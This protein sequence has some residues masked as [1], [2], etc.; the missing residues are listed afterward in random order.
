M[1]IF[2]HLWFLLWLLAVTV[3]AAEAT[4]TTSVGDFVAT[5]TSL[6]RIWDVDKSCD[7]ELEYMEESMSIALDIVTAAHSALKFMKEQVPDKEKDESRY[8]RW[9][10]IYKSIQLFLGFMTNEQPNYLN[11]L[12]DLFAKM[13]RVIPS[14]ENDPAKGYVKRLSR[15]PDAKPMMMCR[16]E[17]GE[18]KWKWYDIDDV[19]PGQQVS[20]A[21]MPGFTKYAFDNY[22]A[23]VYGPRFTWKVIEKEEPILCE[24]GTAAAVAWVKGLIIFCHQLFTAE[25]KAMKSPREFRE[26][27]IVAGESLGEYATHLS[28]VMVHELS[29]WFGG[30]TGNGDPVIDDQTALDNEGKPLYRIGTKL[31]GQRPEPSR[32]EAKAMGWKRVEAYGVKYICN[33]AICDKKRY[34]DH[35]GPGKATKN[36][37]SLALFALAMYYD[38]WDWSSGA[39][40]KEPGSKKRPKEDGG[41]GET[42]K[43][44]VEKWWNELC[45]AQVKQLPLLPDPRPRALTPNLTPGDDGVSNSAPRPLY[46]ESCFWFKVPPNIRRDILRLAF[47]DTRLHMYLNCS[48]PEVPPDP[49]SKFHC[50]ILTEPGDWG[51]QRFP[52]ADESQAEVWQ[53]WGSRCHRCPPNAARDQGPMTHGGSKG[54]WSDLCRNGGDPDICEAWREEEGPSACNI[55]VIGWLLSC[56]QNYMET[57]EVLYST[58]TLIL[59]EA[60]MVEHLPSLIPPRRL[61]MMTSLEI[62]WILKS[63]FTANQDYDNI[64]EGHLQSI[65]DLLSPSKFPALRRLHIWFAKD[66]PAWLSHHGIEA[67]E[68]VIFERLDS[69]VQVWCDLQECA[70]A[71]PRFFFKRKY[72]A[73]RGVTQD[74]R[75][76]L[77]YPPKD[78]SYR[79]VWRDIHGNMTVVQLP[80]VDSYPK[81]PYHTTARDD[82]VAGYW[83]LEAP[84]DDL[85]VYR[86][87]GSPR[88]C[89]CKRS[90]SPQTPRPSRDSPQGHTPCFCP[91][92]PQFS[93]VS[94][95]YRLSSPSDSV[96]GNVNEIDHA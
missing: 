78:D 2:S 63:Y 44:K 95:P 7:E 60:C 19:L 52:V 58:N 79:Q 85:P 3:S 40:A 24:P 29:H 89:I 69:F 91:V 67:Y 18:D 17:A 54:P 1:T 37:D 74:E 33:L 82:R 11:E 55:G 71:L 72:A 68:K 27:G 34:T 57:I 46:Q 59:G 61:E 66:R 96:Q 49:D 53:W 65:F 48:Y 22:G 36:A 14:Q 88:P 75:E 21:N 32:E 93:P 84:Y 62:T 6:L 20:I 70:F 28:I 86:T 31:H 77:R 8:R 90:M 45:E 80:Y 42:T 56:R 5:S 10:T 87:A 38:K 35:C 13:E 94:P 76:D 23:W 9:S 43:Q 83:I 26:S 4:R 47:G 73:A 30:I 41:E 25:A 51:C 50:R 81:A 39:R 92:S 15:L 64:D 16:D 12:I